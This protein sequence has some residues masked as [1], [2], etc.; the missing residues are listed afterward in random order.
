MIQLIKVILNN[1]R[2]IIIVAVVAFAVSAAVS[3]VLP[4]RYRA[5]AML[6]PISVEQD[7]T[8]MQGFL[9]QLGTFGESFA[10]YLRARK[11]YVIDLIIR[12]RRMSDILNERFGLEE[13]YKVRGG[14]KVREELRKRTSV[15]IRNEGVIEL[16]VEDRNPQRAFAIVREYI[17]NVDSLLIDVNARHAE[18][19]VGFLENEIARREEA[20]SRLDSA[21]VEFQKK[22][23]IYSVE[24]Q[25]RALMDIIS[26]LSAQLTILDT[27]KRLLELVVNPESREME[28]VN[29][30]IAQIKDEL[31]RIKSGSKDADELFPP[32]ESFPGIAVDYLKLASE[33]RTQQFVVAYLKLRLEDAKLMADRRVSVLKVLDP[34]VIPEKRVWPKRK[35]IVIA[36]TIVALLWSSFFLMLREEV[37]DFSLKRLMGGH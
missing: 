13:V 24:K 3:L 28:A 19:R 17:R 16:T 32:L 12:S 7:V 34:P 31:R 35:Q 36:S 4:P 10:V 26:T 29:T 9:T 30:R 23:R 22:H 1:K 6:I 27:E 18:D 15:Y 8:G 2:F 21:L 11:D 20:V 33:I 5:K 25:A 14:D 37:G